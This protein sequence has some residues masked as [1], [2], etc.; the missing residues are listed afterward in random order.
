RLEPPPQ[1][2]TDPSARSML[3]SADDDNDD[4]LEYSVYYRGEGETRWKLMKDKVTDRFYTW[5]AATLPD[6]AYTIKVVASDAPSNPSDMA[7]TGE[8]VSDRFEVDNTPPRLDELMATARSR[9]VEVSFVARDS[10]S[11]LKKAEYSLNAGDWKPLFPVEAT[12]DSR[13]HRYVFRLE[14]LEPGEHTVVVRVYDRFDN[15]ALAK[16]TFTVQ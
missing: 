12:T 13:E 9:T 8:N 11:P 4:T 14:A 7:L 10:Y 16:T 2:M 3:W 15:P 1:G 6:G 5:D